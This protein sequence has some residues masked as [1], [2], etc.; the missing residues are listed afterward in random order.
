MFE[1]NALI[2]Q[3]EHR[4]KELVREAA[5][6]RLVNEVKQAASEALLARASFSQSRLAEVKEVNRHKTAVPQH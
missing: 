4:R 3:A 5:H 1:L 6:R 2:S